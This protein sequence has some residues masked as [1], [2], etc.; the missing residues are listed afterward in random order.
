MALSM[1]NN[2]N[3][4]SRSLSTH[5]QNL[6][7]SSPKLEA[8]EK[9]DVVESSLSLNV[10]SELESLNPKDAAQNLRRDNSNQPHPLSDRLPEVNPLSTFGPFTRPEFWQSLPATN[11]IPGR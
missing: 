7:I 10:R 1:T 2:S 11:Q 5:N 4:A 3:S 8:S 9:I 6:S